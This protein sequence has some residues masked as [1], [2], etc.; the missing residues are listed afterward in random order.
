MSEMAFVNGEF[1][2][3]GQVKVSMFDRGFLF[4]DGIYE[5]TAVLEGRMVDNK[6]HLAR[7]QN[8]LAAI[9]LDYP[10]S[11]EEI[12]QI[13]EILI[14][15]SGLH[16]G[17]V[18]L[19]VTRGV[20]ERD[21]AIPDPVRPTTVMFTKSKSLLRNA[22]RGIAV[23]TVPD[24]RWARRNVKSIGLLP[25]VL[26]KRDAHERGSDEAW[27]M[28]G[29]FIT[30]GA[31]ST[32][33]IVTH[34]GR[35]VTRP[36]SSATLTGCTYLAVRSLLSQG[37]LLLQERPFTYAEALEAKEA[38]ITSATSLVTPVTSIDGRPVGSGQVGT[39][40]EQV[41]EMYLGH[42]LGNNPSR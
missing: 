14:A 31:S 22:S 17:L 30:E 34:D 1:V 37:G 12:E 23:A 11:V 38:F 42:A 7:L 9:G 2:P 13:Q 8:S 39:T 24:M 35:I 6:L 10:V 40:V 25:Q 28:D 18:Y 3:V 5:V 4:A 27:M 19:Q 26:A 33:Y 21:F 16:E 36:P 20:A 32:A 41:R 15:R 29:E